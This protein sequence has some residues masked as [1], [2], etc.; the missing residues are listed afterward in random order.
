MI[1]NKEFWYCY[2][3]NIAN[4][5]AIKNSNCGVDYLQMGGYESLKMLNEMEQL[6]KINEDD[7][8]FDNIW[9]RI[10]NHNML[11]ELPSL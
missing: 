8:S 10:I 4:I 1:L 6:P 9:N 3:Q 7:F 11:R 2:T 5:T